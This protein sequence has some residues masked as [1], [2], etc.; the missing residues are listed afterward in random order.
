MDRAADPTLPPDRSGAQADT[1]GPGAR[2]GE[3]TVREVLYRG[4]G[5]TVL[6]CLRHGR[7]VVVKFLRRAV[8]D[9]REVARFRREFE[10]SRR[11]A[12]PGVV[13]AETLGSLDGALYLT[14]PDDGA[15]ALRELLLRHGPLPLA[16]V[17]GV[18]LALVDALEAVHA[19]QI[20]H[21]DLA[22][23]NVVADLPRGVVRL[24]DFGIAAEIS[25]ERPA[26][27][28]P[29]DLEGT[30]DCIAPEQTGRLNRDVDYRADFYGLGATLFALLAGGP[31]FAGNDATEIVYGHLALP[32]RPLAALR[33]DAPPL[34]RAL[35]GKLLSKEPEDRY[36]SHRA[37]RADL[38]RLRQDLQQAAGSAGG[39][40]GEAAGSPGAPAWQLA[41]DD[42][43]VRF[44]VSGRLHGRS[45]EV[46]R[47]LAAFDATAAGPAQVVL[48]AGFSGIGK[49]ALVQEVRRGLLGRRG[50][51]VE[52]KFSQF[53]AQAPCAAFVEALRQRARQVLALHPEARR[54]WRAALAA[55]LGPNAALATAAVPELGLLLGPA[56]PVLPL[57]P[58]E[59]ENRFL[60]TMQ[61]GW[62]A[63]ASAA[64]PLVLFVDDLQWAD[65]ASRRLL[66][67]MALDDGLRHLLLVGAYRADE[68]P[69]GHPLADDLAAVSAAGPHAAALALGPL[70]EDD[71][72]ALLADTLRLPAGD[73]PLRELARLCHAKTGGNPFFL[74]RFLEDLQ[75][76]GL[77]WPDLEAG[78]WRWSIARIREERIA[79]NV[80]ALMLGQLQGLPAPARALLGVAA[81]LHLRF[82][83]ATLAVA[84]GR[85]EG[86]VLRDLAPALAAG[87]LVP[88]D[89]RY[90]WVAVLDAQERAG[91]GVEL[92]FVH[93]R[94]QEAAYLLAPPQERPGL[95]LRIGRLLRAGMDPEAPDFAVVG[96][97]NRGA[98]LMDDPA[99]RAAL[100]ALNARASERA[101]DAA[102]FDLAADHAAQ[103]VALHGEALWRDDP[104][105]ALALQLHAARMAGLKGDDGALGA[106]LEAAVARPLAPLDRARLLDVRIEASY[107]SGRLDDTLELGLAA[108]RLLGLEPPQPQ[109]PDDVRRLVAAL[110][111]EIDARGAGA[112]AA[113]PPMEAA[114]PLQQLAIVA[115]MTAAAY[116]ARPA[117]LP[118]LTVLQVRL[119]M[120]HGHAPAALSAYSV[121]GLLAAE[122]LGDYRFGDRLGRMSLGLVE[123]H[124]WRQVHA[125]AGF[126]FHAFLHHWVDPLAD[127]L[128]ALL[129][130]HRNGLEY[131]NLRHAGLGLYLH[132]C[133]AVLAGVP[134]AEAS[135]LLAQHAATLRRIRQPVAHDYLRMLQETVRTLQRPDLSGPLLEG[136][137]FSAHALGRGY[138]AR[139]DR[140]GAM[141]LHALRGMLHAL[142]GRH[143]EAIADGEAAAAHFPAA[144]GMAMVPFCVF[145]TA[146]AVLAQARREGRPG[147]AV[148]ALDAAL[149]RFAP[150]T[151]AGERLRPLEHLLRAQR[152]RAGGDA[153]AA[154]E[155]CDAALQAVRRAEPHPPPADAPRLPQPPGTAGAPAPEPLLMLALVHW[156][157]A[158]L[159]DDAPD[160]AALRAEA[161]TVF[162]RWGAGA[163][164]PAA[165]AAP[166]AAPT[167]TLS[168]AALD[169]GAL[170]KAVQA[171]TAEV[172]LAPLLRRLLQ[173]L[174]EN[175]GAGRAA[176]VLR[177]APDDRSGAPDAGAADGWLLEADSEAGPGGEPRP[178]PESLALEAAAD[179]LPLEVLRTALATGKPVLQDDPGRAPPWERSAHFASRAVRSM[180][181]L[182]LLRHGQVAGAL[183]LE[184]TAARGIFSPARLEFLEL[185]SGN[186][187]NALVNA[188]LVAEL[189]RLTATL[190]QRVAQRTRALQESEARTLDML[191]SIP[192]PVTV[193]RQR[194]SAIVYA[195]A[196]AAALAGM[197]IGALL[198]RQPV[199]L[200]RRPED[201]ERL[202]AEYR[203][204]GMVQDCEVCLRGPADSDLWVLL[205]LVP[206][207][208]D[209]EPANLCT[210]VDITAR[211]Q[212]ED[213]LRHAAST[214]HLTGL[215][216][217]GHFFALA[218]AALDRAHRDGLPLAVLML[219]VDHFKGINDRHGHATGDVALR[220]VADACAATVREG[221]AIGRLGGEEFCVLMPGAAAAEAGR[222]AERLRRTLG[223]LRLA[224]GTGAAVA[225]TASLGVA[226]RRDGD[227]LDALMARADAALYAAKRA[228][229]D[230]VRLADG[231]GREAADPPPGSAA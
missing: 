221:D 143:A 81:C 64:H 181:C 125:H 164:V 114:L 105:A 230:R 8:L 139:A 41:R 67:A 18:G 108:L 4:A 216:S 195:N 186:L 59:A 97:L 144:R 130:V 102:S 107:A 92:A 196:R 148:A 13:S 113:L 103:A 203:R 116:I 199:S 118:P 209:G 126:S 185:L 179:R 54:P 19:R 128:P 90:K 99:E 138:A 151:R 33:P 153:A 173:V 98:A 210:A 106:L 155:A 22:P 26:L 162:L 147:D 50:E 170:M 77:V 53:G 78:R 227:R 212:A 187:V 94:V 166:G 56:P 88:A 44:Q 84:C 127:T 100:A 176:V 112:L 218:Q 85:D 25:S 154:R 141:F 70:G 115:K 189:Q 129:E 28:P 71:V 80:V 165:P 229:R 145:F 204:D 42:L 174:Q 72:A 200:Y 7:P 17:L 167:S 121:A 109:A 163:V 3:F 32:P 79:D 149:A 134:L 159:L 182:P 136:E 207:A 91:L 180:L 82:P 152:A 5:S 62:A 29:Q 12:H 177:T 169:L 124:G 6:R 132:G 69:P 57:P 201:R 52:G 205:S 168:G 31:P 36:Q 123:R 9:V 73:A 131:G 47:L 20:V 63:L 171:V 214:D 2:L 220:A 192:L 193:I 156:Q 161:R 135:A 93:D 183:Y 157:R 27:A 40:A 1:A 160:A 49:S 137:G 10:L 65:R 225:L 45:E 15:V 219:D 178:V 38:L 43:P 104:A 30:L 89:G 119:M 228:G 120:E 83:L 110:R 122:L 117:L 75:R 35:V 172:A 86:A 150:W 197:P 231:A 184:S 87:L 101:R 215:H 11:M 217:R 188:R 222:L 175:A 211:R 226:E 213:L 142:A 61:H 55:R 37:L 34:L 51:M 206:I 76:R 96:H 16:D 190:E 68:V 146:S 111:D 224:S 191:R 21:K 74:G 133:H 46:R 66:R 58:A 140:T 24:I 223:V 14:M 48:I 95:H 60:L 23:G 208:Y 198:E 202:L 194:D 158:A 39:R